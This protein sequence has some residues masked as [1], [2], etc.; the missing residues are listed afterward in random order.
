MGYLGQRLVGRARRPAVARRSYVVLVVRLRPAALPVRQ[1]D[2][3]RARALR[4]LPR[5]RR[6]ARRARPRRSRFPL[7]FATQLLLGDH[8]AGLEREPAV[9]RERLPVAGRRSTGSAPSRRRSTSSCYLLVG[10]PWLLARG[11]V[12]RRRR[13]MD[14]LRRTALRQNPELGD[15]PDARAGLPAR[16][17]PDRDLQ[18]SAT[19]S[20]R[21]SPASLIGQLDIE[22][23]SDRQ[24]RLLRPLPLRDRLQGRARSSSAASGRTRC[25][26]WR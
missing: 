5:R 9:R 21:C 10:T 19:S 26:R 14:L 25:R 4:R 8:A 3:A 6:Q 2:G 18:R 20:A 1:P 16:A 15:L 11:A 22:V 12:R 23:A 24:D 17:D 13:L 7:L